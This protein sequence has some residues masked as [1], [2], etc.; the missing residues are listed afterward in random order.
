MT[1]PVA[2]VTIAHGRHEHLARQLRSLAACTRRPDHV[3]D[4][5]LVAMGDPELDSWHQR[6]GVHVESMKAD[7]DALPLAAARNLGANAAID[8]GAETI[9]FLDVDCLPGP[10]LVD[11]Y[12]RAV[13]RWPDTIW[14][15]PVTYLPPG[16]TEDQLAQPQEIDDPHPARPAPAPG[17]VVHDAERDLFWSLSFALDRR[18]WLRSG[19]FCE[20]Y[21]G[22]GGEDT[23][24]AHQAA[25]CGLRF[26]WVGDARAY[27]QHHPTQHPPVQHLDDILRNGAIFHERWGRW[28]MIGWLDAFERLGLVERSGGAWRRTHAPHD[29]G[30]PISVSAGR[31]PFFEPPVGIEPTT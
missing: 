28:P 9:V 10:D 23:D 8:R 25:H 13:A 18:A 5:V 1:R 17:D 20:R 12:E 27:H 30:P 14:S 26:G 6:E 16:L 21:V 3:L 2:V 4:H 7:P 31:R 11:G 15:G 24:F 29:E 22:Y 19:G